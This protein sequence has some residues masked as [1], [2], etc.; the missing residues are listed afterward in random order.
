MVKRS[1]SEDGAIEEFRGLVGTG[2]D[3]VGEGEDGISFTE[4]G[5]EYN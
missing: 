1:D 3:I 2:E 4:D 5:Y